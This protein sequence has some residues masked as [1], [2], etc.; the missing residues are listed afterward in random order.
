MGERMKSGREQPSAVNLEAF[1]VHDILN[2][3][4]DGVYVTDLERRIVFWNRAAKEITGWQSADILG[5]SCKDN[6]LVHVDKDGHALCGNDNCPLHRA[7]VTDKNSGSSILVFAQHRNG[8]RVPVEVSV[9]PLHDAN[10]KVIGGI[11]TFRDCTMLMDDLWRAKRIQANALGSPKFQDS[12]VEF[13]VCYVPQEIIG[14][15]FYHVERLDDDRFAAMVVDFMGHGVAAAL[16]CMQLRSLWDEL[17]G[18]LDRPARFMSDINQRIHKLAHTDGYFAT[19]VLLVA[20]LDH[21]TI[22]AVRAGHPPVLIMRPD[23]KVESF[24][25]PSPALGLFEDTSFVETTGRFRVGDKAVLFTDGATEIANRGDQELGEVG[26]ARLLQ[27]THAGNGRA[28]LEQLQ[29]KL[30][31]FSDQIQLTDDLTI[32]TIGRRA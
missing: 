10:G 26:L 28:T 25:K 15:D 7:I 21:E 5:R 8:Q 12:R 3:M 24:G 2:S 16:Y 6:I 23:K 17:R 9:A 4:A 14:G 30:L 20:D 22:T 27:E 11:E 1:G 18:D 19:A 13:E 31:T 29:E 32:L